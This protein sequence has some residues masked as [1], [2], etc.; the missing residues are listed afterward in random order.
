MAHLDQELWKEIA[1]RFEALRGDKKV[2]KFLA[3]HD[4]IG[5]KWRVM[6]RGTQ[7]I[8][9]ES[10]VKICR[11]TNTSPTWLLFG[12][13]QRELHT[14]SNPARNLNGAK[15][16]ARRLLDEHI[17][18]KARGPQPAGKAKDKK[19]TLSHL[20]PRRNP[21]KSPHGE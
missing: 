10:L 18:E 2:E 13:G 14:D 8:S 21:S 5:L 12:I 20:P 17:R 16:E 7:G 15:R 6:E 19:G 3:E 1:P 4:L 11:T 9:V